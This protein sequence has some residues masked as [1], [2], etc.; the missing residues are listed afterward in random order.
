VIT[1]DSTRL[2]RHPN[3][4]EVNLTMF[5]KDDV[6]ICS[7][8]SDERNLTLGKEYTVLKDEE[9]GIFPDRPIV[10][11]NGYEGR[12]ACHASRFKLKETR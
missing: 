8:A 11:V 2:F 7:A 10:T 4:I 1:V 3:L 5:K 12:L 9:E 6:V